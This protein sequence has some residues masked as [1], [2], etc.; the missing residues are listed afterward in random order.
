M[1]KDTARDTCIVSGQLL[2]KISLRF[3]GLRVE[4]LTYKNRLTAVLKIQL[5][6]AKEANNAGQWINDSNCLNTTFFIT[7]GNASTY[8]TSQPKNL[9]NLKLFW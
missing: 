2:R 4:G 3:S 6:K 8:L 7:H 5:N 9:E 1:N